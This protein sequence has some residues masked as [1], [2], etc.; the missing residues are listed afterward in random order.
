MS[1]ALL[2]FSFEKLLND[3]NRQATQAT[4]TK[5]KAQQYKIKYIMHRV[6]EKVVPNIHTLIW[7]ER[8]NA[9]HCSI[10]CGFSA[11]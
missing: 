4:E 3:G 8:T 5:S 2:L 6:S 9:R 7:Y 1:G 11:L 10:M